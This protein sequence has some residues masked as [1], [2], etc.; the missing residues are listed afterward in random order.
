[1]RRFVTAVFRHHRNVASSY[2]RLRSR[3]LTRLTL[4]IIGRS[5]NSRSFRVPVRT[6]RLRPAEPILTCHRSVTGTAVRIQAGRLFYRDCPDQGRSYSRM[7][8]PLQM[9]VALLFSYPDKPISSDT[10]AAVAT[11][12]RPGSALSSCIFVVKP[13]RRRLL[14][15]TDCTTRSM[16]WRSLIS[17]G[18]RTSMEHS[19]TTGSGRAFS[20][21][22]PTGTED[23]AVLVVLSG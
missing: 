5:L 22:L 15:T 13:R 14:M 6:L 7:C 8:T 21:C 20:S 18:C 4:T 19:T 17:G 3:S 16:R 9:M 10:S 1:M 12:K 2:L 23:C 11:L